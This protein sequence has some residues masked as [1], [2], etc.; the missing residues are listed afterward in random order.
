M[1]RVIFLF[2]IVFFII[3]IFECIK[4]PLDKLK[5]DTYFSDL[6]GNFW[7]NQ[8]KENTILWKNAKM[9]CKKNVSKVNCQNV[10]NEMFFDIPD[11]V[12]LYGRSGNYIVIK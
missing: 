7:E 2:F 8:R 9:Y 11:K 10:I 5:N 6:S 4:T 1:K 12:P 3:V